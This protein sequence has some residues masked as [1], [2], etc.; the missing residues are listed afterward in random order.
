M[1]R[2]RQI[3]FVALA[4]LLAFSACRPFVDFEKSKQYPAPEYSQETNWIALPWR[5][6]V[7]DMTP[8][9]CSIPEKQD[10]AAVDVFYLYPTVYNGGPAWNA[11]I[12]NKRVNKQCD[13]NVKYQASAF[14]ACGR[15]YAPRYR[16][17]VLKSFFNGK[18]GKKPL[19]LAYSDVKKAFEYYLAHWNSGR[20]VI[21]AGHSQGAQHI[22]WLLQDF[23]DGKEMQKKLVAAYP[24]GMHFKKEDL[25]Q[26]PVATSEEQTGC[27][28]TWNTFKWNTPMKY[29]KGLYA[30]APCVNPL[31]MTNS[32]EY[33]DIS[34]NKGGIS[35][36][37][38]RVHKE[39]CD[40]QVTGGM[41]WI[42][43]PRKRGYYRIDNSY[44]LWDYNLFYMNIRENALKR[45]QAY[46]KRTELNKP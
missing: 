15:I 16:Q 25:K 14:N 12:K 19:E 38:F 44:H 6:D 23:F 21:L 41:L 7:A 4:C 46:M 13:R 33:A 10:S 29:G 35:L 1:I 18:K 24:V 9:G 45:V 39:V 37:N 32:T 8:A 40:G 30:G 43:K 3:T 20:P 5:Y 28:I 17:A 36:R 42:H 11:D 26:I 22:M 2:R 31:L 27:F 34:K